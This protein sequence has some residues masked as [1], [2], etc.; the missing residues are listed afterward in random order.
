M[1]R[2]VITIIDYVV[3]H[4]T[5]YVL[6]FPILLLFSYKCMVLTDPTL[7]VYEGRLILNP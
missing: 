4:R 2:Q 6:Y 3:S 5:V 1:Q 7:N